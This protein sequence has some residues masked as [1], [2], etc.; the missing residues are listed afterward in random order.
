MIK[1][2]NEPDLKSM[3]NNPKHIHNILEKFFITQSERKKEELSKKINKLVEFYFEEKKEEELNNLLMYLYE[4]EDDAIDLILENIYFHIDN[5]FYERGAENNY[6]SHMFLLP[7]FMLNEEGQP[8]NISI[9]HI[10]KLLREKF[11]KYNLLKEPSNLVLG[12]KYFNQ[13]NIEEKTFHDWWHIHRDLWNENY[14]N[15][16]N[17]QKTFL[18][19][20]SEKP[21][22]LFYIPVLVSCKIDE[23]SQIQ[24]IGNIDNM[25]PMFIEMQE[26]MNKSFEDTDFLFYE[27]QKI[28]MSV[29]ENTYLYQEHELILFLDQYKKYEN[30][31]LGY[32]KLE[33]QN[34]VVVF[35]IDNSEEILVNFYIFEINETEEDLIELLLEQTKEFY[36]QNLWHFDQVLSKESIV[37]WKEMR[38]KNEDEN[39]NNFIDLSKLLKTG[40]EV[41]I[42]ETEIAINGY[43]PNTIH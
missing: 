3:I 24:E 40:N 32:I 9:S 15:G 30:I 38:D 23:V 2:N 34:A 17:K 25:H 5:I 22:N 10:E 13:N 27:L 35:L 20:D 21:L 7:I 43:N 12:T 31:D 26:E 1:K 14:K 16:C 41:S 29:S 42:K 19:Y 37:Y 33:E 18:L 6:V 28:E 39:G 8:P 11:E 4:K 36:T